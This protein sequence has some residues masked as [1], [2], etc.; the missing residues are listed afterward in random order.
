MA[1]LNSLDELYQ[2]VLNGK[3]GEVEPL[4]QKALVAH[5]ITHFDWVNPALAM[6]LRQQYQLMDL[7]S[8]TPPPPPGMAGPGPQS[9]GAPAQPTPPG[10]GNPAA[11]RP[12]MAPPSGQKAPQ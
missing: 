6:G 3:R 5:T 10:A 12:P 8:A 9:V 7:P 1:T 2:A 11:P 4:V